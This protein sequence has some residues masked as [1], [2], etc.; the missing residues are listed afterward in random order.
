LY[1]PIDFIIYAVCLAGC[2]YISY[3]LGKTEGV[4]DAVQYFI[5]TGVIEAEEEDEW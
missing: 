4:A 5:D 1:I 3:R 2:S